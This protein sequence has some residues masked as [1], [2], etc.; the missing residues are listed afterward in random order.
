LFAP[1]PFMKI[2][3]VLARANQAEDTL[4]DFAEISRRE[5]QHKRK[6]TRK[7]TSK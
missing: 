6:R 2:K 7:R 1:T 5:N 3:E 4:P